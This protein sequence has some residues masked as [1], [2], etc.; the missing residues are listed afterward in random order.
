[1]AVAPSNENRVYALANNHTSQLDGA[2]SDDGGEISV[3]L[4]LDTKTSTDTTSPAAKFIDIP[5]M[6]G[7]FCN[8]IGVD[9]DNPDIVFG[10]GLD[11]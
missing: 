5:G 9:K 7:D 4:L 8:T 11:V 1:M 2:R 3:P 6:Q 10:A